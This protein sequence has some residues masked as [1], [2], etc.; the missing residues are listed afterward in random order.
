MNS[1]VH[2]YMH[3]CTHRHRQK[4]T[5]THT[6]THLCMGVHT[7]THHACTYTCR[8]VWT[9]LQT[10]TYMC[11][12]THTRTHTCL[13]THSLTQMCRHTCLHLIFYFAIL[14]LLIHIYQCVSQD[15]LE[16]R[17]HL[18]YEFLM[19]GIVP[20]M[21]K[22]R[23]HGNATLDRSELF[24]LWLNWLK[25]SLNSCYIVWRWSVCLPSCQ[26]VCLCVWHQNYLFIFPSVLRYKS[27]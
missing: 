13:L 4:H 14:C 3:T 18:R 17:L 27:E 9:C 1:C 21:Q 26:C 11:M 8:H 7:H 19:L 2:T 22:L 16:F 10:H 20:I 15:H 6:C 23:N 5:N 12:H 24:F 25:H